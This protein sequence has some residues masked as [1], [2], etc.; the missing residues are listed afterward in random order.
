MRKIKDLTREEKIQFLNLI[1]QGDLNPEEI[2]AETFICNDEK[3]TFAGIMATI[4]G[5]KVVF[6]GPA[7]TSLELATKNI[8]ERRQQLKTKNK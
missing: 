1:K 3:E 7:K 5:G 6:T 8:N 2:T 4:A